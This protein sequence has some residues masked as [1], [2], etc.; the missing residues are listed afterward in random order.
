MLQKLKSLIFLNLID[1]QAHNKGQHI[2][3]NKQVLLKP[4]NFSQVF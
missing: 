3:V 1:Y 2:I 4:I